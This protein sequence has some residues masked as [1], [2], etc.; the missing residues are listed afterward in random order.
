MLSALIVLAIAVS[1]VLGYKTKRN[2][3]LFAM[4]FAYVFGCFVLGLKTKAVI[5]M[6]PISV[7][8]VIFSVSLFYNFA[9]V[10]G[11][12]EKMALHLLYKC[13]NFPR[14]L[15]YVLF[16]AAAFIA[17]I[18]AGF[19]AVLAVMA[20]VTLI[21]CEK[22][23]IDKLVGAVAINCGALSGGNFMISG[24]GVIF[25]GLMDEAG[26]AEVSFGYTGILFCLSMVFSLLFITLFLIVTGRGKGNAEIAEIVEPEPY[27]A[28]QRTN[29]VLIVLMMLTVLIPPLLH[30]AFPGSDLF[31]KINAR[32]DVGLVA[33]VYAVIAGLLDL[34]DEK[35]IIAKLPWST[36][37]MIAG[38]GMLIAVAIKAGTLNLL[39]EWVK[40]NVPPLLVPIALALV[41]ACMSFFSS[42]TGVV[43]PALFPLVPGLAEA[44]GISPMLLFI[45]IVIGA[46]SSAISPFSSGGSLILGSCSNEDDRTTLFPRLLFIAVPVSVGFAMLYSFVVSYILG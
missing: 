14:F 30:I 9:M 2:T 10:N 45:S 37:I 44:T 22:A 23:K 34:G 42:T 21:L 7:F 11:T 16:F 26:F 29:I 31:T 28:K 24:L 35:K 13:R 8:F 27:D 6:W 18:G 32:I 41:G 46:Q 25:R 20:P 38:V 43:C 17:A 19:F 4:F 5:G 1:V 39:T 3:G 12:L 33:I 40:G 15:P 36:L